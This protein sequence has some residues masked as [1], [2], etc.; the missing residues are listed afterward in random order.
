MTARDDKGGSPKQQ[1]ISERLMFLAEMRRHVQLGVVREDIVA[2]ADRI[3]EL[4]AALS[5]IEAQLLA[6]VD[7]ARSL[8][9]HACDLM[10]TEQVG[11]WAG[12]R[13]W[14]ERDTE[15]YPPSHVE[16]LDYSRLVDG[17]PCYRCGKVISARLSHMCEKPKAARPSTAINE[18]ALRGAMENLLKE[19]EAVPPKANDWRLINAYDRLLAALPAASSSTRR[20]D[21]FIATVAQEYGPE[22]SEAVAQYAE[23]VRRDALEEAAQLC[24]GAGGD[25][26]RAAGPRLAERIRALGAARSAIPKPS[27]EAHSLT[28]FVATMA[29]EYGPE[30]GE[31]AR[32]AANAFIE[33]AAKHGDY[34][35]ANCGKVLRSMMVTQDGG[36]AGRKP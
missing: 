35:H 14:L 21:D 22:A 30:A 6:Q 5:A 7:A 9:L 18:D 16:P 36:E 23:T 29:Q 25:A 15:T 31:A 24:D 2:A 11:Q 12:V 33:Q 26:G 8:I 27:Q 1:P 20:S 32:N 17:E 13:E 19:I 4:E 3:K 28:E 34:F 10:T